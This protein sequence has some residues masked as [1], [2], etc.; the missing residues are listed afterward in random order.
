MR[1]VIVCSSVPHKMAWP[2]V[3]RAIRTVAR[4]RGPGCEIFDISQLRIST[5]Q[6][7][8]RAGHAPFVVLLEV[9]GVFYVLRQSDHCRH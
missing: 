8:S 7:V 2:S 6:Y 5:R 4:L 1:R 9:R 3:A